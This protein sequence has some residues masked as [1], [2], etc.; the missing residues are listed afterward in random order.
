MFSRGS[1]LYTGSVRGVFGSLSGIGAFLLFGGCASPESCRSLRPHFGD[2]F[3]VVRSFSGLATCGAD[4]KL[5]SK[6]SVYLSVS[7]VDGRDWPGPP[8]RVK[9]T[10]A[11]PDA[12]MPLRD[13]IESRVSNKTVTVIGWEEIVATGQPST[14]DPRV[15]FDMGYE[16]NVNWPWAIR[17]SLSCCLVECL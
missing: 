2:R 3:G 15:E 12:E 8:I 4:D 6:W 9:L 7:K 13:L 1:G 11:T 17:R 16:T 5:R 14:P 10:S